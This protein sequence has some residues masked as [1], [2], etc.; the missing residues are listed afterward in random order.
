MQDACPLYI[1]N[2]V[3]RF[4]SSPISSCVAPDGLD[5]WK[6]PAAKNKHPFPDLDPISVL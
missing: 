5:A 3:S 1:G 4:L 2:R 6:K